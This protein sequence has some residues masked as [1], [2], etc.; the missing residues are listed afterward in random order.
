MFVTMGA[1]SPKF[2]GEHFKKSEKPPFHLVFLLKKQTT[3]HI[4]ARFFLNLYN[5][6]IQKSF[7]SNETLLP[8]D[9]V[10][11]EQ[12][13]KRC[14]PTLLPVN[15]PHL[16]AQDPAK[17]RAIVC[18]LLFFCGPRKTMTWGGRLCMYIPRTQL[19]SI[20]EGQPLQNKALSIQNRG[21]LGSRY[22]YIY[23]GSPTPTTI[24]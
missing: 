18:W 22:I 2:R 6:D 15:N 19:T 23:P 12:T 8:Q 11:L 10:Q 14:S 21:H 24:F 5:N 17:V 9:L 20:F 13:R 3:T 16:A 4:A 7:G 1:S